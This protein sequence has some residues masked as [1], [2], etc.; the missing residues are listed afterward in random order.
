MTLHPIRVY[1]ALTAAL[2]A[3]IPSLAIVAQDRSDP[4]TMGTARSGVAT[5]RGISALFSNPG[6]LDY[7]PIHPTTLPQ[8]VSFSV[9]S[10]GGT[11]GGTYLAG[12]EF[13]Q[14]FGS[15]D[16]ATNE[17]RERIG[18]LLVDERLFANAGITFLSG[19]WRLKDGGG[20]IGVQYGSRLYAR[21][22]F[23]DDLAN[24]IATSNIAS[25]DFRFV[26][27]G[28]GTTWL[29]EFGVSYGR[30]FGDQSANGWFPSTGV[31]VTAKLLGGVGHFDVDENSAIYIDQ[32]NV[33]G[34]LG[35]LVRG[36]YLFRSAEP[37]EF[38]LVNAV[39]SF[40][41]NPFPST[42]GFGVGA[43]LGLNGVV[44]SDDEK[45]VHYGMV[46]GNMGTISWSTKAR[47]RRALNFRDTLGASL[48]NDEFE[49]F[50]GDL[51][52]VDDYSTV[53]PATFRAGVALT[54]GA[55]DPEDGVVTFGI[56][57]EAPLNQVPGNTPDPRGSFGVDWSVIKQL[58]MR[59]GLSFGG[60][61][62]VGLGFG[63]GVRPTDWLS[64]DVGT[65]EL[66][67]LFS[68]DRLDLAARVAFGLRLD[69]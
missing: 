58:S 31:G 66:N 43:D 13:S 67:G 15:L 22:N 38:D 26:N 62:E 34:Q 41:S 35:F 29:T 39:G 11:V 27:R 37:E 1:T 57:G 16:G 51:V 3:A 54:L 24:L 59:T 52:P 14:I 69:E 61:S 40:F 47:E 6:A 9:Y 2:L 64:I 10:G 17:Q 56:E 60:I 63:I 36:G 20:T 65:S 5:V 21:V 50:E 18:T 12:D 49:L 8:D 30:V 33:N 28:I 42:S 25:K 4:V 44:Y 19:T 53:L 48:T 68:G 55:D 7:Y 32:I 23:P 46:L 45:L